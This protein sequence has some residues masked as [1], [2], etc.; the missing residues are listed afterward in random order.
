M[1]KRHQKENRKRPVVNGAEKIAKTDQIVALNA[2]IGAANVKRWTELKLLFSCP[3]N[4]QFVSILLDFAETELNSNKQNGIK[5]TSMQ[6][7]FHQT[8]I[9]SENFKYSQNSLSLQNKTTEIIN[10]IANN[11]NIANYN[12]NNRYS[13]NQKSELIDSSSTDNFTNISN[14][15]L[16]EE[17]CDDPIGKDVDVDKCN[18]SPQKRNKRKDSEKVKK[19]ITT[20]NNKCESKSKKKIDIDIRKAPEF[21]S[22]QDLKLTNGEEF[23]EIVTNIKRETV[24]QSDQNDS[25]PQQPQCT[26]C[27]S[28]HVQIECPFD[29]PIA[30][31]TDA[32]S[33]D[34]W[35]QK[36]LTNTSAEF[37]VE[38]LEIDQAETETNNT[39]YNFK[40]S[41]SYLSLPDQLYFNDTNND[42][43]LGVFATHEI[44]QFTQL[45]PIVGK[46]V[47]EVDVP[48]DSNMRDLWEICSSEKSFIYLNTEDL[49]LSNWAR[50]VRPAPSRESR[51]LCVIA[52]EGLLYFFSVRDVKEGEELMYWQDGGSVCK[53]NKVEKT[54]CGGCNMN[55][56]H[57]IYYRIHCNIFHDV[58]YSLTIRKYHCKV[59]GAAVL[60]KE[61]IM[62]H[63]SELHNGQGAYQCQFCKKFFLRLNYLEMHRT[64]GCSANPQRSRPL[65]DFCGRKF[66]QPQKLKVHIK[67]MHGDMA[68]ILKDFQCKNCMKILGSKA[69]LQRHVKEVHQKQVDDACAC[70]KCGKMFQNKSNLK[71]HMLTHSGIKPFRCN[72]KEC[73]AAFT[74]KQCLQFHYKKAH[75]L[76]EDQMPKIER[77]VDYTFEAYSGADDQPMSESEQKEDKKRKFDSSS[78]VDD[79]SLDGKN[80]DQPQQEE[81]ANST[82][83]N[84]NSSS[85]NQSNL[86]NIEPSYSTSGMKLLTKG[87]KKW[88]ASDLD[89]Y[90][91]D[92][93]K[94]KVDE[95]MGLEMEELQ[96]RDQQYDH[97]KLNSNLNTFN[98]QESS[99]ASLLVE[100]ALDSVC[101]EP[102]ID[103]D[104]NSTTNCTDALVNNLYT[105]SHAD[106]LPDV[107]Y[108]HSVD[109]TES[110]D[111][112]LIS[113]SVNDH[114]SVTDD[115]NDELRHSQNIRIDYSS[116]PQDDFSPPNSPSIQNRNNF[117]RDYINS[118]QNNPNYDNVSKNVSPAN[119]PPRYDFSHNVNPDNI[120][121]DDSNG[122]GVQ[123]LSIHNT[124]EN[125]QLDLSLYKSHYNLDPNFQFRKDF[126]LKFDENDRK[127][128]L[129]MDVPKSYDD[130]HKFTSEIP[131]QN[132]LDLQSRALN[133]NQLQEQEKLKEIEN[134]RKFDLDLDLRK[135]YDN[136][137]SE[138]RSR[139]TY[140]NTI[141]DFRIKSYDL[142]ENLETRNSLE[143][144][145]LL[146]TDFRPDRSFEH[147]VLNSAELQ[148]LDMSARSYHNYSNLNRYHHLYSDVDRPTV[149]L[150]LNY[151]SPS[152][153]YTHADILRVV[154]L[155]LTPPGRHSVDLSLR[156]HQITNSR[157]LSDHTIP[158]NHRLSLDQ[159]RLLSSELNAPRHMNDGRLVSVS[160]MSNRILSDHSTNRLL[161]NDS[162]RLLSSDQRLLPDEGRLI[163]DQPRLLD[164]GRI[165]G[166][167]RILPNNGSIS[168]VPYSG[169][170]V[171][172]TPYH[173]TALPPRPHVASP[174]P[175]Y[176]H[177]STYY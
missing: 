74:T 129:G 128:Y 105:L 169:Y 107:T 25:K 110:R 95:N 45:G 124:K 67:R 31:L 26:K 15:I 157:L 72:E 59:C 90:Q 32:L 69:A 97:L 21:N 155:D 37:K 150:R 3:S 36:N 8:N 98:R 144:R 177:Y 6:N 29:E 89:I 51:N 149:D 167:S 28:K 121:S 165:L 102:N 176:H 118:P 79:I 109:M 152:Q 168:P 166:D 50:F 103:I 145:N 70:T 104:V 55:F 64:Y 17:L 46:I 54:N 44:Q 75:G 136:L 160:D 12:E 39:D 108:S 80:C 137:D 100:A 171:S 159:S 11:E 123:N 4:E 9:S 127:L 71:I 81:P 77:S 173:P 65:C 96:T 47:K 49:H 134:I 151:N 130:I 87:S 93:T 85:S 116:F 27:Y 91:V 141:D 13:I 63:A 88:M 142:V 78:D 84:D 119:S 106:A 153:N 22:A 57:P 140:D 162:N 40:L 48:E 111:I 86:G 30:V 172:P 43:G 138:L 139:N 52:K 94:Q 170:S 112:N 5:S 117:V 38:N 20:G 34:E 154:S 53:K 148:G 101:S 18:K 92:K 10:Q 135:N 132:E 146:D 156:S 68:D 161:T 82:Q 2:V 174:N 131:N 126:R 122:I 73:S 1:S 66:C 33:Y 16:K 83:Q 14:E 143:N 164:Q 58:R 56:G 23:T 113:P 163:S 99:N 76:L 114:I 133:D 41:Y 42:H 175:S 120:S 35:K 19:K 7:G 158:T 125:A 62:K 60:G 147:L 115:L 24:D 61:N